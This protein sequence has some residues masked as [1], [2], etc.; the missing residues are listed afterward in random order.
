M[1]G[2]I[3]Q[4]A[5]VPWDDRAARAARVEDMREAKVREFLRDVRSGLLDEP[6]A[7]E[8]YRRMRLAMRINGHE[9]PRHIGLLLFS[10][11]PCHW[12]RGAKIEVVQF[13]GDRSGDVQEER[14]FGGSLLDQ[15]KSCLAYLDNFSVVHLR[16]QRHD[17]QAQRWEAYPL[18]ALRE[19][20]VNAV[21]HRSYDVDQPEPTKVY[22]FPSRI[23]IV[24]YPGPVPGIRPEHLSRNAQTIRAAP[25]RNRRIGEFLK[26]LELAEGRL[27]GLP[28][29]YAAMAANGSPAPRFDFDEERTYFQATFPAHPQYVA[30]SA[31]RDAAHLRMAGSQQDAYHR[32]EGALATNRRS[33]DAPAILH[34]M[35]A[36]QAARI[37]GLEGEAAPSLA[38]GVDGCAAGWFYIALGEQGEY[39]YGVVGELREIVDKAHVRDRVFVDIPIGL[40][41]KGMPEPRKFDIEARQRLGWPRR[42][43]VFPAP[44]RETLAAADDYQKA[45]RAN[46]QAVG[47]KISR[48]TFGILP[49]IRD[50]DDLLRH[51]EKARKI[52]REVHPELCFWELNDKHPMKHSKKTKEGQDERLAML[53]RIWSR[54]RTAL[55]EICAE[56]R[57]KDVAKDD[58]VDA[59][60]AAVAAQ[61]LRLNHP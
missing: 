37:Q 60:A 31:V 33:P 15:V 28:K 59:M 29:I 55:D 47:R 19:A 9:V 20:L 34:E 42:A 23:E 21:Y 45:C 1:R 36:I 38:W 44:A 8:I 7:R 41:D 43:S 5:R 54:A 12:F 30:V 32:L 46:Q 2:L 24:S 3:S 51:D 13:A 50:A 10:D 22:I 52:V 35:A 14:L 27:S 18:V 58:I 17:F 53:A 26:E 11:D 57:R 56:Y 61:A 39:C 49:K 4:T 48:Q 16:K 6:D 25:A 40:P